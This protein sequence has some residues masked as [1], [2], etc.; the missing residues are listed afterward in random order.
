MLLAR[1]LVLQQSKALC[2]ARKALKIGAIF[3]D[4]FADDGQPGEDVEQLE[5]WMHIIESTMGC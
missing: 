1:P 5:T 3:D 2:T 4:T